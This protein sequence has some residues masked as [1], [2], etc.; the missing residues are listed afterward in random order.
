MC[1]SLGEDIFFKGNI[2]KPSIESF[3]ILIESCILRDE[4]FLLQVETR[5]GRQ[6]GYIIPLK[7]TN[8]QSQDKKGKPPYSHS[9]IAQGQN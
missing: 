5:K 8:I 9:L 7:K 6:I 3:I 2:A 1:P 4:A